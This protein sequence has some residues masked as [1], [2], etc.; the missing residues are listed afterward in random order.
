V[1]GT[2]GKT[3]PQLVLEGTPY[4]MGWHHGRLLRE[5]IQAVLAAPLVGEASGMYPAYAAGMRPLLP[6]AVEQEL[7][8]IAAGA[9]IS[10]DDVFLR[11]VA[12]DARRWH[13][14]AAPSL[15][16]SVHANPAETWVAATYDPLAGAAVPPLLLISRR[17]TGGTPTLVL[18]WPGALGAVAGL[19]ERGVRAAHVEEGQVAAEQRTL[20]GVPFAIGFR[21]AL[22]QSADA[23][24][25][26]KALQGLVGNQ[27]A[28]SDDAGA[29]RMGLVRFGGDPPEPP[30]IAKRPEHLYARPGDTYVAVTA[31]GLRV[32]E[33]TYRLR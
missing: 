29:A 25:F 28:V 27:V 21:L 6:P 17:P 19:S 31:E 14:P 10:A 16:G 22:E 12:R 30:G 1:P 11:E 15:H 2:P 8:G 13:D 18:A 3:L 7:R 26:A 20:R 24:A 4:E 23:P 5:E 32:G 9:G 33:T